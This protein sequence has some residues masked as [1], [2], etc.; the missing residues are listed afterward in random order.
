MFAPS[1]NNNN[2]EKKQQSPEPLTKNQLIQAL[3]YLIAND[4]EFM[5]KIHDA[6]LKSF[7]A[8]SS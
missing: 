2:N 7:K 8:M 1:N 3:D 4:D 6:Y 5:M